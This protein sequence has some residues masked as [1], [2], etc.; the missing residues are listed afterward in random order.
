LGGRQ[1][2]PRGGEREGERR[3]GLDRRAEDEDLDLGGVRWAFPRSPC[4]AFAARFT[5]DTATT[6]TDT[7]QIAYPRAMIRRGATITGATS[8]I[9]SVEELTL[10]GASI[11]LL[12]VCD[13]DQPSVALE[14]MKSTFAGL[15]SVGSEAAQRIVDAA[16]QMFAHSR[17]AIVIAERAAYAAV[18]GQARIYRQR[19]RQLEAIAPGSHAVARPDAFVVASHALRAEGEDFFSTASAAALRDRGDEAGENTFRNDALDGV[20]EQA[21]A[22]SKETAV[23][24][25]AMCAVALAR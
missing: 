6:A 2:E 20:L 1:N 18:S 14:C 9:S 23:A 22:S 4:S 10:D 7:R 15:T 16:P 11:T 21:L 17:A 13:G 19:A 24:V 12:A 8:A 5:G 3:L 25:A